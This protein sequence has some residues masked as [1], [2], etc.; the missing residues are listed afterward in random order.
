MHGSGIPFPEPECPGFERAWHRNPMDY[1]AGGM[2]AL[3]SLTKPGVFTRS[4]LSPLPS[5]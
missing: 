1:D 5:R 4:E 3:F 2:K